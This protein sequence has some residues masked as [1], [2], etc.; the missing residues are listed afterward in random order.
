MLDSEFYLDFVT[1][2]HVKPAFQV[3]YE[4]ANFNEPCR[5]IV[6]AMANEKGE[7][8]TISDLY[9]GANWHERETHDFYGVVFT[10]HPDMRTLLLSEDDCD[11]KPLLKNDDKLLSLDAITRKSGDDSEKKTVK[12]KKEE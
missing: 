11:L 2:V 5:L 6:K 7:I 8:P 3:V 10:G 9:D 1:A 12:K 4:F